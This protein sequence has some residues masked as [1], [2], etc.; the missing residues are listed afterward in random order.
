MSRKDAESEELRVYAVR[1]QERAIRDLNAAYVEM[2][3]RVSLDAAN[4]WRNGLSE[5]IAGLATLPRRCPF[6][7]E[8]FKREVRRLLYRRA[9]NNA[10]FYVLFTITGEQENALDPPTVTLLHIRHASARP[11]TKAE[12]RQIET[13]E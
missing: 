6:A 1:F 2:A 11:L 12:A 13:L 3:E 7:P 4:V 5:S 8:K 10:A 9:G